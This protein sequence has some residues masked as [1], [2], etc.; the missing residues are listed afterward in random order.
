MND[1]AQYTSFYFFEDENKKKHSHILFNTLISRSPLPAAIA[2][3]A[4]ISA[5][6]VNTVEI[7]SVAAWKPKLGTASSA[8]QRSALQRLAIFKDTSTQQPSTPTP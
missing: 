6:T 2:T 3:T 7:V 5:A 1:L 4:N 8:I